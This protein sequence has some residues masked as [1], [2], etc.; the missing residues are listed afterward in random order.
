MIDFRTPE[1]PQDYNQ[2]ELFMTSLSEI[3]YQEAIDILTSLADQSFAYAF[4]GTTLDNS[5]RSDPFAYNITS[6]YTSNR[7]Y[8]VIINTRAS[9]QLIAG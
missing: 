3:Q 9:K 5:N 7:F 4:I 8:G 1:Q 2:A 6:H